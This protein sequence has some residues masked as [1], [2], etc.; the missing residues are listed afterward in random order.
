VSQIVVPPSKSPAFFSSR[1]SGPALVAILA[2]FLVCLGLDPAGDYPR[3]LSGPGLTLDEIFNAQVGVEMADPFFAGDIP[4]LI[5]AARVLPDH[6][7]L[8]RLWL[9]IAHEVALLVSAPSGEHAPVVI[10]CARFG[11]AVAF[12]LLIFLVGY[13]SGIWYG[14][15]AGVGASLAIVLMP[16]VFGHAHLA[17]LET[18]LNLAYA[19]AL[20]S[21]ACWWKPDFG[22]QPSARGTPGAR[23]AFLSGIVF[24]LT[25][26]TKIQAI[27]LPIPIVLWAIW[28][29]RWR[30]IWP[31]A[32]WGLTGVLLFFIGWPWLWLD[33]VSRFLQYFGHASERP[34]IYVWYLGRQFADR[35]VPWHYPWVMFAAT[36]P[37]GLHVL[38][39]WGAWH[40]AV[41]SPSR[42]VP[43]TVIS[44]FGHSRI[45]AWLASRESL[46]LAGVLFPLGVFSIPGV[47]V[48]D[49]ERLFSMVFPLWALFI[50]S[51]LV[52]GRE[53]I[54]RRLTPF[55]TWPVMFVFLASQSLGLVRLA[56][57]WLS[58]YSALIGG[59]RGAERLGLQVTYWGDSV[60][61]DLLRE[62]ANHVPAGS[63]VDFLPV[64]HPFQLAALESQSPLL[65]DRRITLRAFDGT[66]GEPANYL[67][68]FHRRDYWPHD[69]PAEPVPYKFISGTLR[70]NVLLAGLYE[71]Q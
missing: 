43:L 44:R 8:G 21:V 64:Q 11:S 65:R 71:R 19:A 56:P 41:S 38:G 46:I 28:N 10:A 9:G 69:W 42:T 39:C 40:S 18:P 33:P 2:T 1:W 29:W 24:G 36:I 4:K 14:R 13:V 49:G 48:Y 55:L 22:A 66:S 52:A 70:Q 53:W 31:L 51:G 7:P 5:Q 3:G 35:E 34:V 32:V 37:I 54:T 63:T 68:V 12:G 20:L 23:V 60:T 57:C 27:F 30:A 26:L 59:L 15:F 67:L 16:R 17:A 50:G 61:R 58:Y 6:P 45:S 62:V 47:A 25:L